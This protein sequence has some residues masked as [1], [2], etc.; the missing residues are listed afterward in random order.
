MDQA[1]DPE[2][3]ME[4]IVWLITDSYY[5]LISDYSPLGENTQEILL[6]KVLSQNTVFKIS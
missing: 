6:K 1:N 4:N 3:T 2:E 5:A